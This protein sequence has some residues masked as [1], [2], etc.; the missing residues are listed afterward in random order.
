MYNH[1]N[2]RKIYPECNFIIKEGY[3]PPLPPPGCS[4][5]WNRDNTPCKP[6]STCNCKGVYYSVFEQKIKRI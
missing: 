2:N 5:K 6:Q 1:Y 4:I 3:L